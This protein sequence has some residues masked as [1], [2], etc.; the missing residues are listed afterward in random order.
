MKRRVQIILLDI[1]GNKG[2]G[3]GRVQ[4][5]PGPRHLGTCRPVITFRHALAVTPITLSHRHVWGRTCYTHNYPECLCGKNCSWVH[6][7]LSWESGGLDPGPGPCSA[8]DLLWPWTSLFCFLGL[9]FPNQEWVGHG[10]CMSFRYRDGQA[11]CSQTNAHHTNALKSD[12][13]EQSRSLRYMS[14]SGTQSHKTARRPNHR[15]I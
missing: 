11:W 2:S 10:R 1:K 14:Q 3:C 15:H 4:G 5:H 9:T 7:G 8:S 12:L 6:R 13:G